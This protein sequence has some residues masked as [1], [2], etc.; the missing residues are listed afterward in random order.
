MTEKQEPGPGKKYVKLFALSTISIISDMSASNLAYCNMS[1]SNLS[2]VAV[3]A[4]SLL[5]IW[6]AFRHLDPNQLRRLLLRE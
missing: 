4:K 1:P 5:Q 3:G 6:Y 2:P